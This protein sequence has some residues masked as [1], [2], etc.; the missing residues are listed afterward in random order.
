MRF[1]IG[2]GG[3]I[4]IGIGLLGL[5]AVVFFLGMVTGREI[6]Q[7]DTTQQT[8][9]A[10]VY[11]LPTG[12]AASPAAITAPTAPPAVGSSNSGSVRSA[13][14]PPGLAPGNETASTSGAAAIP[15]PAAAPIVK[16]RKV[17]STERPKPVSPAP[18][19]APA[20]ESASVGRESAAPPTPVPAAPFHP[21]NIVIDAA[22]DFTGANRM[23]ARLTELGYQPHILPTQINGQTWYKVEVG[24]YSSAADARDAQDKL[25]QDYQARF[26]NPSAPAN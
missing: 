1:E 9:L 11:P 6:T 7:S 22:M 14:N 10:T 13:P 26:A 25:R 2:P 12:A 4:A 23:A 17:V 3:G 5:S 24:P 15:H 18:A 21:Y 8:E 20:E 19:A 16:P